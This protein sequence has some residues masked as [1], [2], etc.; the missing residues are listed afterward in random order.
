MA[1]ETTAAATRARNVGVHFHLLGALG[2][3]RLLQPAGARQSINCL[4]KC[5]FDCTAFSF[6]RPCDKFGA[7]IFLLKE[8][9]FRRRPPAPSNKTA[10]Q[11]SPWQ[12][13]AVV[14]QQ[15]SSS[16]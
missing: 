1:E 16:L 2:D 14:F 12:L 6:G 10:R 4:T 13:A 5:P 11:I 9:S 15:T 7:P 3:P 8:K